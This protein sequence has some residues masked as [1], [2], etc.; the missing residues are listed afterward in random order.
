MTK[1][2]WI[3]L[4]LI[5]I[6]NSFFV[7]PFH[8]SEDF[9]ANSYVINYK[10]DSA[11]LHTIFADSGIPVKLNMPASYKALYHTNNSRIISWNP[12][13]LIVNVSFLDDLDFFSLMFPFYKSVN[14]KG[15]ITFYSIIKLTDQP[16]RDSTALIGNI[17]ISTRLSVRGICT[18]L[19]VRTLV[20]KQ[21]V[22]I[23]KQEMDK[24]EVDINRV[25]VD[26]SFIVVP[27]HKPVIKRKKVKKKRV[28]WTE[29]NGFIDFLSERGF[30]DFRI[31]RIFV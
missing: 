7:L 30:K 14:C 26:T 13:N 27:V 28:A 3:V 9:I 18:P 10:K 22:D 11:L 21:F 4:T 2:I 29:T 31:T 15:E 24:V 25:E 19:Y 1:I 12:R 5:L 6:G 23:L 20:E 16:G 8:F 17:K